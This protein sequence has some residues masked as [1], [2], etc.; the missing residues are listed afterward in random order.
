MSYRQEIVGR[1]GRLFFWCATVYLQIVVHFMW[2]VIMLLYLVDKS[3]N[4]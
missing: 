3:V 4:N 2:R 1:E